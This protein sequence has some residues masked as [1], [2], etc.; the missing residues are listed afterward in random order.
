MLFFTNVK[1]GILLRRKV[2]FFETQIQFLLYNV[3]IFLNS[4]IDSQNDL[5]VKIG[6]VALE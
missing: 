5:W 1:W 3:N 4:M 6:P 2:N